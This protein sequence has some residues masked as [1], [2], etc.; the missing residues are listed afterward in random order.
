MELEFLIA[1][2]VYVVAGILVAE[3][4]LALRQRRGLIT[5]L[6]GALLISIVLLTL[7]SITSS[8]TY[9]Y[10]PYL[11]AAVGFI[12]FAVPATILI[13]CVEFLF[14]LTS[15]ICAHLILAGIAA[16]LAIAFPFWGLYLVCASGLE[17]L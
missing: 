16:V 4:L 7:A 13:G 6:V 2:V 5:E 9:R 10:H 3:S 8:P 11:E 17:C 15:K 1:H 12:M 14:R